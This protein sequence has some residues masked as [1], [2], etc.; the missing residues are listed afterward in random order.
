VGT[1]N[2]I[3]SAWWDG[4]SGWHNWFSIG[5]LICRPGSTVNVVSRYTDHLDV[6]TT[7]SDGRTMSTWWDARTG[8]AED[9][10]HVQGGVAAGGRRSPP[11]PATPF[12]LALFTVGT[13]NRVYSCWWDERSGW[14]NWFLIGNLVCRAD[15]HP[16][17]IGSGNTLVLKPSERDPS[18]SNFVA[19]LYAEAACRTACSTSC[20]AIRSPSTRCSIIP[21]SRRSRSWDRRR[22]RVTFTSA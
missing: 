8:W 15:S 9:L 22:S 3:Y 4:G 21:T 20:M 12:H 10:F 5:S 14:H 11:S 16:V 2:R 17:A 6:F 13:D 1:D 19:N 18:A 7:A